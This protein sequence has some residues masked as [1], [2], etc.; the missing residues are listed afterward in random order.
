MTVFVSV[1]EGV[2]EGGV[3]GLGEVTWCCVKSRDSNE[4]TWCYVVSRDGVDLF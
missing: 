4:V 2:V 1:V 3:D